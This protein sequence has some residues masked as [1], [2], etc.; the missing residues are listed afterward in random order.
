MFDDCNAETILEVFDNGDAETILE[1][2]RIGWMVLSP[3]HAQMRLHSE[4][5]KTSQRGLLK[6]LKEKTFCTKH[7]SRRHDEE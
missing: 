2:T 5:T 3:Q 1:D 6:Y 4:T 7:T